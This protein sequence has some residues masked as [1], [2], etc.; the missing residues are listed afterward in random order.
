MHAK[1]YGNESDSL[2]RFRRRI[3]SIFCYIISLVICLCKRYNKNVERRTTMWNDI[4]SDTRSITFLQAAAC[5]K[6]SKKEKEKSEIWICAGGQDKMESALTEAA[7]RF[8]SLK[9]QKNSMNQQNIYP[10]HLLQSST[11]KQ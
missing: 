8:N 10:L 7:A 6:N 2:L 1:K 4:V 9:E 5:L 3:C 11:I